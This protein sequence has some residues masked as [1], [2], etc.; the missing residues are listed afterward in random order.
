MSIHPLS[1]TTSSVFLEKRSE[2]NERNLDQYLMDDVKTKEKAEIIL[3]DIIKKKTSFNVSERQGIGFI[4]YAQKKD[5]VGPFDYHLS[6]IHPINGLMIQHISLKDNDG[7]FSS[8][9]YH[10]MSNA[11]KNDEEIKHY[12]SLRGLFENESEIK[13]LIPAKNFKDIGLFESVSN[14]FGLTSHP[15]TAT[16]SS[17]S[18]FC[19]SSASTSISKKYNIHEIKYYKN[20]INTSYTILKTILKNEL[21]KDGA[22]IDLCTYIQYDYKL[23][24]R[25]NYAFDDMVNALETFDLINVTKVDFLVELL[26]HVKEMDSNKKSFL[27]D[28]IKKHKNLIEKSIEEMNKAFFSFYDVRLDFSSPVLTSSKPLVNVKHDIAEKILID[29]IQNID[30]IDENKKGIYFVRPSSVQGTY[31]IS[32]INR[33]SNNPF[34]IRIN[35][36]DNGFYLN[37]NNYYNSIPQLLKYDSNL[38]DLAYYY[39]LT[40]FSSFKSFQKIYLLYFKFEELLPKK[41]ISLLIQKVSDQD[42]EIPKNLEN[43][44]FNFWLYLVKESK[45]SDMNVS[46]LEEL[47]DD[48]INNNLIEKE[49]QDKIKNLRDFLKNENPQK[50]AVRPPSNP[51]V[52]KHTAPSLKEK[53]YHLE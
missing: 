45:I 11:K 52:L 18:A 42:P 24:I 9:P 34:H 28:K 44:F 15:A 49:N 12:Q 14:K 1:S 3:N 38:K 48:L 23:G 33:D 20:L 13:D 35:K 36:D 53:V 7:R 39:D 30:K 40:S 29:A 21:K 46:Y 43:D 37:S 8:L 6:Y 26:D 31:T 47:L 25:F 16:A 32:F 2:S 22:I 27:I 17:A 5:I 51:P 19:S 4:W 10:L 50:S 41:I